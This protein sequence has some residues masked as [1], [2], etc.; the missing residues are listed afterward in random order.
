MYTGYVNYN[1]FT[2][3]YDIHVEFMKVECESVTGY[4]NTQMMEYTRSRP[5]VNWFY[6]SEIGNMI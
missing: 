4:N 1:P 2:K 6:P 5:H 3:K